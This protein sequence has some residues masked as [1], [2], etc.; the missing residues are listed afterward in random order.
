MLSFIGGLGIIGSIIWTI[1]MLLDNASG[2]IAEF[3]G[4]IVGIWIF[5]SVLSNIIGWQTP[6]ICYTSRVS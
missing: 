5:F 1:N 2:G 6:K 4:T 3:L